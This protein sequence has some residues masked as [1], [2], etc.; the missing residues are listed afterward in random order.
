MKGKS[1]K[2]MSV[3]IFSDK[4]LVDGSMG[5]YALALLE[6]QC[7]QS[8]MAK[9]DKIASSQLEKLR[10]AFNCP[11]DCHGN[12]ACVENVCLCEPGYQGFDCSEGKLHFK[13]AFFLA[14]FWIF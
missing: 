3:T 13:T 2:L 5:S 11:E 7:E 6:R 12:G 8:V 9:W 10:K 1:S 4:G 14:T